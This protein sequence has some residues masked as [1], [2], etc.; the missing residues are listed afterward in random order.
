VSEKKPEPIQRAPMPRICP[1]CGKA[2][3]SKSGEHP[4][5]S[6]NRSDATWNQKNKRGK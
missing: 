3:Y 5:C 4:Q 1:V 6:V 2:S